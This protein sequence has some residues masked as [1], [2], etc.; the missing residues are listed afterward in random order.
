MVL[1]HFSHWEKIIGTNSF[2]CV[3][4]LLLFINLVNWGCK[5][6]LHNSSIITVVLFVFV[7]YTLAI[8]LFYIA[9]KTTIDALVSIFAVLTGS[10]LLI[11]F[12]SRTADNFSSLEFIL[13][14]T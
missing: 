7:T 13:S 4:V 12:Y 2:S 14:G 8:P 9:Y 5:A 1:S 6:S 11:A 10:H 3:I